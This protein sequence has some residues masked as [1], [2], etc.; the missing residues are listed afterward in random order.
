MNIRVMLVDD[1]ALIRR[2][3]RD[4]LVEADDIE[5][6]G[7]AAGYAE[8]RQLA[9]TQACD[10]LILDINMP[11]RSGMEILEAMTEAPSAPGVLMLS[12]Y[13]EDQYGVRAMKAGA[14]GYLNKAADPDEILDAVRRIASG[15]KVIT[16]ALGA[17][18]VEKLNEPVNQHPH[19]GL[20]ERELQ[21]FLMIARGVKL[22]EMARELTLSTKTV[23]VYRARILEKLG[24]GSNAEIAAYALRHGLID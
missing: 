22:A 3:L 19:Q 24:L 8:W 5:V 23:S 4:S 6:V 11:G 14:M 2:G 1:H 10:V 21:T 20:S 13:G 9:R 7:E 16:P 12:Q 15:Q 18:L 17:A